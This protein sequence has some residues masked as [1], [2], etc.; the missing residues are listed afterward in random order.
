MVT[1]KEEILDFNSMFMVGRRAGSPV[2]WMIRADGPRR[3]LPSI[4]TDAI[5][6][7]DPICP[8]TI[9]ILISDVCPHG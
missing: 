6:G 2:M 7:E 5:D 3:R 9:T 1:E 4:K 8:F